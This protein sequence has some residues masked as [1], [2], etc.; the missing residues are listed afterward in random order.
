M[1]GGEGFAGIID[2]PRRKLGIRAR[3]KT[4]VSAKRE[5]QKRHCLCCVK[6]GA[7]EI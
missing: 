5:I 6:L 1:A 7:D 4:E 3:V 2:E